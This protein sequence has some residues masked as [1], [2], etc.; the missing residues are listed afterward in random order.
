VHR[1]VR[2]GLDPQPRRCPRRHLRPLLRR[3]RLP[4][5]LVPRVRAQR[6]RD[7]I[8]FPGDTGICTL[9]W[10]ESRLCD[11]SLGCGLNEEGIVFPF[12]GIRV[13]VRYVGVKVGAYFTKQLCGLVLH[14]VVLPRPRGG[15]NPRPSH[16]SNGALT[17]RPRRHWCMSTTE[18]SV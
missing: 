7:C 1:V 6:R 18:M 14:G 16:K 12:L 10:C 15:S 9:C 2:V 4:L 17:S 8:P 5:R 3:P 11:W 13:S